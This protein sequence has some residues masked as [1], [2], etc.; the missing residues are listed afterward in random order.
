MQAGQYQFVMGKRMNEH[1]D[2]IAIFES[3]PKTHQNFI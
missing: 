2:S 1:G 3:K